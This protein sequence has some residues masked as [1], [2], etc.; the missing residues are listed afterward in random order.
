MVPFE[1]ALVSS[2]KP[3]IH[4]ISVSAIVCSKFYIAVWGGD[5][6]PPILGR[7][8]RMGS[9]MVPFERALVIFYRPSIVT[10]PLSLR[11]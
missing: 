9:G 10:F 5:C 6:E 11:V 2:Y 4:I 8:G 3:S 7:G 1:R